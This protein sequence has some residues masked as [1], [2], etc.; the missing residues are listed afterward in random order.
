VDVGEVNGRAFL[1]NSSLGLYPRIVRH[2]EQQRLRLGRGKWPA[3]AWALLSALN[4]CPSLRLRLRANGRETVVRTPF[5]FIGN[6]PYSMDV[7]RVGSRER[8]DA[9]ALGVYYARATGRWGLI[10]LALRSLIGR[11]AQA[12]NFESM[13]T[14]ELQVETRRPSINVSTDGEV[15]TLESPLTYRIR[16]RALR[17]IVPQSKTSG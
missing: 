6:N 7:L 4:V 17:V 5:L 12:T 11:V 14:G 1:N 3:F 15:S 13:L 2:R 10:A 9:G 8:L 16:P